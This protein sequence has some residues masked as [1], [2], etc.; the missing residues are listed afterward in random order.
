[1][2]TAITRGLRRRWLAVAC[3]L[4]AACAGAKGTL[5][6][7][8]PDREPVSAGA[9]RPDE[10]PFVHARGR[11]LVDDQGRRVL[12]RGVAFTNDIWRAAVAPE[13]LHAEADYR[14]LRE[15]GINSVRFYLHHRW[16]EGSGGTWDERGFAWLSRNVARARANGIGLILNVHVPPGGFQSLGG[17]LALWKE[18]RHQRRFVALWRELARRL[19]DEPAVFGY[20]L[21]NEPVVTASIDQWE[22]LARRTVAAIREVDRRHLVVI[23]RVNAVYPGGF[24]RPPRASD[25]MPDRNGAFNFFRIDDGNVMYE[26]HYYQ[27]FAF[28]HQGAEWLPMLRLPRTATYPGSFADWNGALTT[29]DRAYHERMVAR[30]LEVQAV[31]EAPLYLGETGVIRAGFEPGRNG[32]GWM[33]DVLGLMLGAGIGVSYHCYEAETD[34]FGVNG[35]EAAWSALAEAYRERRE[36]QR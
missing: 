19:A 22:R 8:E 32:A 5:D 6:L 17:G 21:L 7:E 35:H 11:D 3:L 25:W 33:K 34:P 20:D 4:V 16:F 26:F 14:R 27:P 1:M 29:F 23:E 13:S 9:V 30:L 36:A 18:E 28:T 24:L 10:N 12:L 2:T 15:A 31:L